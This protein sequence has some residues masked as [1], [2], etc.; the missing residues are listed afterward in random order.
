MN[1][2]SLIWRHHAFFRRRTLLLMAAVALAFCTFGILGAL[3]YSLE[4]G[5]NSIGARRL[6]VMSDSGPM[7]VLPLSALDTL[8]GIDA[9]ETISYATWEGLY[10]REQSNMF[11]SFAVDPDTWVSTHP[12]ML[13]DEA[14][15]QAFVSDRRALLVSAD[16][17]DKFGWKK[18]DAVPLQSLLFSPPTGEPAWTF[19][20]AGVFEPTVG[21]AGR[22]YAVSHYDYLNE[23]RDNWKNTVGSYVITLKPGASVDDV[24]AAI[25]TAF[26]TT[27]WPTYTS[28]DQ[29]FHKE[30]FAQYGDI[31]SMIEL[32]IGVTFGALMLMVGSG[33]ALATRQ[34]RRDL[35]VLRVIGYSGA[36]I[37]R[38]VVGQTLTVVLAG[39]ALGLLVAYVFNVVITSMYPEVLP[40]IH[41]PVAVVGQGLGIGIVLG[42][43]AAAI[44]AV[45]ALRTRPIEALAEEAV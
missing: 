43:A 5:D 23:N 45:I 36:R 25:D 24:G 21:G 40:A 16:I 9:L 29:V 19:I 39:A 35:G 22:N 13:M 33:M 34:R 15:R 26:E 17:A 31:V 6:M 10:F 37:L 42:M 30:F 8:R 3:R 12:D 20:V 7:Q 4:G 38:I 41:L 44:P 32:V 2:L 27:A 1:D 28:S 11:M 18:G 14:T